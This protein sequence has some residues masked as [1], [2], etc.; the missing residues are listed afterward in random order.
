MFVFL[1]QKPLE[2]KKSVELCSLQTNIELGEPVIIMVIQ[3]ETF[4]EILT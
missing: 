1:A 2:T 4:H 3:L